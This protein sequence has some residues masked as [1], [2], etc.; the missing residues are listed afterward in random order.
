MADVGGYDMKI[1]LTAGWGV[2]KP[3]EI[4]DVGGHLGRWLIGKN[5][6]KA[7]SS[8]PHDK[9]IKSPPRSKAM[10]AEDNS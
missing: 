2:F 4:A 6:A 10:A 9:M 1:Q 8:A 5:L 3:G 7:V